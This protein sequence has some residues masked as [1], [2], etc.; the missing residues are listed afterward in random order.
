MPAPQKPNQAG[1]FGDSVTELELTYPGPSPALWGQA[2][3]LPLPLEVWKE[4]LSFLLARLS[5][6]TLNSAHP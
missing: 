4:I 1:P 5:N 2:W 6:P 3:Q